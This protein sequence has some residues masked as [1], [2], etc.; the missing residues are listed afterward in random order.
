MESNILRTPLPAHAQQIID[1]LKENELTLLWSQAK[2]HKLP[3]AYER[4][5]QYKK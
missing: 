3:G 2:M 5:I 1:S 4:R